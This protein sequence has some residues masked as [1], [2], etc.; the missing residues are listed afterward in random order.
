MGV[1]KIYECVV[2]WGAALSLC[3][4]GSLSFSVADTLV[5]SNH[6]ILEII[7]R[8][9]DIMQVAKRAFVVLVALGSAV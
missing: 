2:R 3:S 5:R 4:V 7:Q 8:P 6:V 9:L 1:G